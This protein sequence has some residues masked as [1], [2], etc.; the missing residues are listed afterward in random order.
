[1]RPD[2]M[3]V[4]FLCSSVMSFNAGI[5]QIFRRGQ[6]KQLIENHKNIEK[7]PLTDL[8]PESATVNECEYRRVKLDGSFDNE[9]SC[10]VGPRSIPSYKGA[11]N[12]DESRGGF[13]VMTP[14]EIAD[15]GRFVMVNRGWVPIDAGKHRTMLKQY[16]GEGF[17]PA[18]VRG[19]LRKEEFLGGSLFWG[20]SPDNEGPVA[21]DLSWL[22][23][24]PWNMAMTYYRRRW[25]VDHLK[26][27]AEKHGAH[28]YYVEMLEDFS[29]DDQ[30]IVRGRAWP[31]RR[32]VDEVTYVHLT[33][34][35]HSMYI[36]FWFSITAGSLYGVLR[37][38]RRQKDIFALRKYV[39]KQSMQLET[40]RQVE[41]Q[42]YMKAVEEVE[43][44]KRISTA[45]A[46]AQ[47]DIGNPATVTHSEGTASR[48]K[49]DSQPSK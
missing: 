18:Q 3:G 16:I 38:W 7:S 31:R 19:V 21:A 12:E 17:T 44:L 1:M 9:G 29:G 22:V 39:N 11:A 41:A 30:R 35:V 42:A 26:E 5:W 20:S 14:F 46:A 6:K 40:R 33:P 8:P 25:G 34:V 47:I 48:K 43:R 32:E 45:A 37:C 28:H 27:S 4:M 36:V 13:L 49:Y 10:L 24:R 23:V 2:Y 15:T